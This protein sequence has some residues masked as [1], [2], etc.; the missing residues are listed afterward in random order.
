MASTLDAWLATA[1]ARLQELP[2]LGEAA[3][4]IEIIVDDTEDHKRGRRP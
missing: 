2:S 4:V 1:A 3:M